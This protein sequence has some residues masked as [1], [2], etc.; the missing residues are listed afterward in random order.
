MKKLPK[1][2]AALVC[3]LLLLLLL[4]PSASG[5]QT[6]YFMSVNDKV[7]DYSADTMPFISGGTVYVPYKM[8]IEEYNG[9]V[10]LGVF[11]GSS[12]RFNTLSLYSRYDPM[13][14]FDIGAGTA[15]DAAGNTYS[16][17]AIV[18]SG[19]TFVPVSA[20]CSYFG[21]QYS[22]LP[23]D[24]GVL[25][26][27][28]KEGTYWLSDRMFLSS[29]TYK[30]MEQKQL[31]D[32]EQEELLQPSPT[33]TVSPEAPTASPETPTD[34]SGVRISFAFRCDGENGADPLLDA[35]AGTD[36]KGLFFFR[37]EDLADRDDQIR[38]LLAEGHRVGFLTDGATADQCL[39][40]AGEGNRLLAHIARA[41]T[42]FLLV[43]NASLTEELA[44][45]G[46]VCWKG[47][48]NGIP[49]N[50]LRPASLA[51][52][53]MLNI[54]AKRS[55]GRILMDDSDTAVSALQRLIPQIHRGGYTFHAIT[56]VDLS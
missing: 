40:Q 44:A 5:V 3:S 14:T 19:V 2:L 25:V 49:A 42:D 47:N 56:E 30:F 35:F 11:Y 23:N 29:A 6:M 41:R 4:L 27:V 33:P 45:R 46:W 8:F 43:D 54:E 12:E 16:F 53:I 32:R 28:K 38:R 51:A 48:I 31:F 10:Y 20:V 22:Y 52:N 13:L 37:P 50:D 7:L 36:I 26:R 15:Y 18:R 39:Q 21:L 34:K 17:R 55:Y 24:Y 1:K 9:G